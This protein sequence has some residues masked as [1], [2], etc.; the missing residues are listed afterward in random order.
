MCLIRWANSWESA[1]KLEG[2]RAFSNF[3]EGKETDEDEV[4]DEPL[5]IGDVDKINGKVY[6]ILGQ[7][8][9]YGRV[10]YTALLQIVNFS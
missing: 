4:C 2:N 5:D 10:K 1:H 6:E 8:I 3:I 9:S 7:R